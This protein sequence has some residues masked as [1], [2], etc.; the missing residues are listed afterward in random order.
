M[1][2]VYWHRGRRCWSVRVAGQ[3]VAHVPAIVLVGVV[4]RASEAARQRCLR[5]GVR[6]VHAVAR[7]VPVEG[8]PRPEGAARLR[9]RL[10]EQ[11]FRADGAIVTA[12]VTAWF[13][14]DG[15]AWIEMEGG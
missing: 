1:A 9:Y 14:A 7:G 12:A 2:D 10:A 15:S 5:L 3:V 13:E 6:D 8:L 11:G 4:F